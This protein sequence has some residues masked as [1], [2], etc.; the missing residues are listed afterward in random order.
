MN[1]N[2]NIVG[3]GSRKEVAKGPATCLG[4]FNTSV[5]VTTMKEPE[6]PLFHKLLSLNA[7]SLF[8]VNDKVLRI[9][10]ARALNTQCH[11]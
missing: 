5:R 11:Y 10:L 6:Q 8:S 7:F 9:Q 4:A 2:S 3:F 1:R